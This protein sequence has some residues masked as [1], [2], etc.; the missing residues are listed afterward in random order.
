MESDSFEL[1]AKLSKIKHEK[2]YL[3]VLREKPFAE[4]AVVYHF[5]GTLVSAKFVGRSST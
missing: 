2:G 1:T 3:G 5:Y 4:N